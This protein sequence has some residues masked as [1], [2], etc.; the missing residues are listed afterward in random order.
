[1]VPGAIAHITHDVTTGPPPVD[2]LPEQLGGL[3]YCPGSIDLRPLRS[4]K[5]DDLRTAFELNVIGAFQCIQASVDRLKATPGSGVV[6]FSTVAVQRGMP[7]HASVSAAKGA[8]EGLTRSLAAELA[9]AVRVNCLAPSLTRTPL[10][11]KLLSSPEREKASAE[12]HPM[13]RVGEAD[14]P[15]ALAAFLVG[16]EAGWITGQ[17]IGV[18]GGLS[19][20]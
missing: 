15:A 1:P 19:A 20:I 11:A 16:P 17:V 14:D 7:F 6:L 9:P 18:D 5:A 10:A 4:L 13:E 3:V 8:V 2:Q 12:R